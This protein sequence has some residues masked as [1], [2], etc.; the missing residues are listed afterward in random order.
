M[1]EYVGFGLEYYTQA[2]EASPEVAA[3]ETSGDAATDAASLQTVL[4]P[5]GPRR[6]RPGRRAPARTRT[7]RSC[8]PTRPSS[9]ASP[10]MS[11]LAA[12]QDELRFGLPPGCEIQ[13]ALPRGPR[14]SLRHRLATRPARAAAA[15]RR[16]DGGRPG[17]QR[18]RRRLALLHA[19]GH[20][21]EGLARARGRPQDAAAREPRAR[22]PQRPAGPGGGRR[23]MPSPPSSTP[24]PSS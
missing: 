19:A 12:V 8:G 13:P 15:V 3:I 23:A 24:S 4:R 18:H 1:P 14:G 6:H 11:D 22:R 17:G 7:P 2:P 5:G 21:P 20:R 9:S 10:T 16:R